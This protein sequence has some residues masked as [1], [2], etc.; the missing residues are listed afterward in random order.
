MKVLHCLDKLGWLAFSGESV[1][2]NE[3]AFQVQS[4]EVGNF[5][6]LAMSCSWESGSF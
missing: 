4:F 1:T 2:L 6:F 5:R 3:V